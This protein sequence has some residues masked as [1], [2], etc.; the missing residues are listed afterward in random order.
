MTAPSAKQTRRDQQAANDAYLRR[1]AEALAEV[2]K[3]MQAER[4]QLADGSMGTYPK[5]CADELRLIDDPSLSKWCDDSTRR[6]GFDISKKVGLSSSV[7]P[8]QTSMSLANILGEPSALNPAY[9]ALA[10]I[11]DTISG[12]Y[13]SERYNL[14]KALVM[15]HLSELAYKNPLNS[16]GSQLNSPGSQREFVEKL[17]KD[18]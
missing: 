8:A 14:A 15:A 5:I 1:F 12:P 9:T 17:Q 4:G 10:P 13:I 18:P 7:P 6:P 11:S 2:T 3:E 16:P